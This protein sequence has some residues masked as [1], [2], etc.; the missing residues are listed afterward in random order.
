MRFK[1][2]KSKDKHAQRHEDL[3]P[4][5]N[6]AATELCVCV[7]VCLCVLS[8]TIPAAKHPQRS[9][10]SYIGGLH[11]ERERASHMLLSKHVA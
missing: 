11:T 4:E 5:C 3:E 7:C 6:K 9:T 10:D 1:L 2:C 8:M